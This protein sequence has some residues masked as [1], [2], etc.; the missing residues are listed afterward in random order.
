[1]RIFVKNIIIVLIVFISQKL[2]AQQLP[3]YTQY[4]NN[5]FLVNPSMAG[6]DGYTSFNMTYRKQ[7]V[8]FPNSPT[9][10]SLSGQTRLLKQ[11]YHIRKRNVKYNVV[12]PAT[13][14]RV[15]LGGFV[16]NDINGHVS[17]TG[18]Q[19]SYA[20][21]IFLQKSQL[22]FG[23]AGQ[24]FQYKINESELVFGND[25][26]DPIKNNGLNTVAFIPD[27]SAGFFWSGKDFFLGISA[28]QMFQSQL[29]LGSSDL[30]N[31]KLFRHYYLM[32]GYKFEISKDFAIEPST[33]V[34]TSENLLPQADISMKVI[35]KE[36]YWTGLS[37]RTSGSAAAMFGMKINQFYFGY[38]YEYSL[39]NIH[40][41]S[42]GSHEIFLSVKF[43]SSAR[44]YR[45][46]NRY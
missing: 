5:G 11:T 25:N 16:F 27:A 35:Y 13:K 30:G 24:A 28:N 42:F 8:G 18:I 36:D 40:K 3:L 41:Y 19:F 38:A 4:M 21:H 10:Y 23:I 9:T 7:W 17:R 15:G 20:Y 26:T 31:L 32:A 6:Y 33:L 45:W 46:T 39:S 44:R 43:G 29:K 12:K 14:G 2:D 22:S 1:M 37:Y 34:K